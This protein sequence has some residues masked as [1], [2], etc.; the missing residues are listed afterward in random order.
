MSQLVLDNLHSQAP[1]L[2][3]SARYCLTLELNGPACLGLTGPSGSGKS[4]L[5][6]AIADLDPSGGTAQLDG[7]ARDAMAAHI[8]RRRV[9]YLPADSA[10]WSDRVGDHF[11]DAHTYALE[12]LGFDDDVLNWS[13]ARLSSG[14]RQR[15]ALSRLLSRTPDVLLLDEPTASLDADRTRSVES[16]VAGYTQAHAAPLIWVSHDAQQVQRI[17]DRIEVMP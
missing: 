15:L 4:L 11:N 14:E 8:W 10:W 12:P 6:R 5:L 16:I 9:G 1:G 3:V 2:P 7:A 13:V 17:A